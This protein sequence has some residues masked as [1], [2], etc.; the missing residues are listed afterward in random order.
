MNY[1]LQLAM[2][3]INEDQKINHA[4]YLQFL[5]SNDNIYI[6]LDIIVTAL[7]T[8]SKAILFM[9]TAEQMTSNT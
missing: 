2:T 8:R 5:Y 7:L 6:L 4:V 9:K 3:P 1:D